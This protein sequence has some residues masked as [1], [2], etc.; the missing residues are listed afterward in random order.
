VEVGD[1][2]LARECERAEAV[3]CSCAGRL[4]ILLRLLLL[5][6]IGCAPEFG[7]DSV[8]NRRRMPETAYET[9][10]VKYD[11]ERLGVARFGGG[12]D[13]ED[14]ERKGGDDGVSSVCDMAGRWQEL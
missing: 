10:Y 5:S 7:L 14:G 6:D 12:D 1:T 4:P 3:D 13:C 9:G 8:F 11:D 2:R